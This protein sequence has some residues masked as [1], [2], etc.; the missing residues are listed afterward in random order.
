MPETKTTF[1]TEADLPLATEDKTVTI[2]L[3][4]GVEV[5]RRVF[6]GQR[7]PPDLIDAYKDVAGDKPAAKK[8]TRSTSQS[9]A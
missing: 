3:E 1:Y 8:T 4:H 2:E 7:V 6:A 9:E 5:E